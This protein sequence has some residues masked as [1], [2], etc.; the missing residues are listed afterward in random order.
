[1]TQPGAII[2]I[3]VYFNGNTNQEILDEVIINIRCGQ[4]SRVIQHK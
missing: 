3:S 2:T 4:S 1:M